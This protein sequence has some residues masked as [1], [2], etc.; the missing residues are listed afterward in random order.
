[1]SFL[2]RKS[3]AVGVLLAL[4]AEII[5]LLLFLLLC[6][7]MIQRELLP[8]KYMNLYIILCVFL[9][10]FPACAT[11]SGVRGRGYLPFSLSCAGSLCALLLVTAASAK[12]L[13]PYGIWTLRAFGAAFLGASAAAFLQIRRHGGGRRRKKRK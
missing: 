12:G 10:V 3:M 6:A 9:S 8:Q 7:W 2:K 13:E 1:M 4:A 11:I 5:L